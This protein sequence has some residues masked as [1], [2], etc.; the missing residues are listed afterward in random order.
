MT[1]TYLG[2]GG[3]HRVR[4]SGFG[5][6]ET[7]DN[8]TRVIARGGAGNDNLTVGSPSSPVHVPV[9]VWG[10]PGNDTI[11]VYTTAS[12]T[13]YGEGGDDTIDGG[14]GDDIL[15]GGSGNDAY[16]FADGW[17]VDDV[18]DTSPGGERGNTTPRSIRRFSIVATGTPAMA[19]MES[20][21]TSTCTTP[22]VT[23]CGTPA[24]KCGPTTPAASPAGMT[25][26]LTPRS[27]TLRSG[28]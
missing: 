20:T 15:R 14:T 4:V 1:V 16:F 13:I 6:Q 24:R 21:A 10:G 17:G 27:T 7:H 25:M 28:T 11:S 9:Q 3:S 8:V 22:T 23:R 5:V 12:A 26:A 19:L 18:T 2:S